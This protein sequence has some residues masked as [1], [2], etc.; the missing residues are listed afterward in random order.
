MSYSWHS[1]VLLVPLALVVLVIGAPTWLLLR[2][3]RNGE[4]S[5]S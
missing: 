2:R 4:A 3:R 1:L 5:G